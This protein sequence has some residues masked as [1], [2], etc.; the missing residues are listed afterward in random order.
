MRKMLTLIAV[1]VLSSTAAIAQS[2]SPPNSAPGVKGP[3]DTRTGPAT[4][5]PGRR[6]PRARLLG[7]ADS[8][9]DSHQPSEDASGVKGAP[10]NKNGPAVKT[11]GGKKSALR[12]AETHTPRH[13]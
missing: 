9:S 13:R 7:R 12:K 8:A 3:P 4:R 5:A 6:M 2:P 10:G 11:P 1:T